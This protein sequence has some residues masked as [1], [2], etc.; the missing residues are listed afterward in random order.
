MVNE[1]QKRYSKKKMAAVADIG[2]FRPVANPV[3]RRMCADNLDLHLQIYF[4]RS[5]G[6][7][8]FSLDHYD[9]IDILDS[10]IRRGGWYANAVFREFAKTSIAEG[11]VLW[12]AMNGRRFNCPIIGADDGAA[13]DI[14]DSIQRE[15]CEND[16]LLADYPEICQ[17]FRHLE[18]RHQRCGSQSYQQWGKCPDC[19]G[20]GLVAVAGGLD[21]LDQCEECEGSG[22]RFSAVLTHINCVGNEIVLPTIR[23]QREV[24][25]E[26]GVPLRPDG[27]TLG[28]G[29]IISAHGILSYKRGSK[30]KQTDGE[31]RRP[32][33]CIVDDFQTDLSAM[34]EVDTRRR[35]KKIFKGIIPSSGQRVKMAIVVNGT[36]IEP[37]DG[38]EQLLDSGK[39][40]AWQGRRIPI[41]KRRATAEAEKLWFGRYAELLGSWDRN[42]PDSSQQQERA[43]RD[44]TEFYAANRQVMDDGAEATWIYAKEP[45]ELSAIQHCYNIWIEHGDEVFLCEGQQQPRKPEPETRRL[46]AEQICS[47]AAGDSLGRGTVPAWCQRLVCYIDVQDACLY[48]GAVAFAEGYTGHLVDY[49]TYPEQPSG[50]FELNRIKAGLNCVWHHHPGVGR[51][52]ALRAAIDLL[53]RVLFGRSWRREDGR[54]QRLDWAAIDSADGGNASIVYEAVRRSQWAATFR[55]ARGWKFGAASETWEEFV[56][57]YKRQG[58]EFFWHCWET[59]I[60]NG[61]RLFKMDSNHWKTFVFKSLATVPGDVGCL[62]LF[63]HPSDHTELASQLLAPKSVL[64]TSDRG[65]TVEEWKTPPGMDD[66]LFDV[67]YGCYALAARLR[68]GI[69]S[70]P[71]AGKHG[72]TTRKFS[73]PAHMKRR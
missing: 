31:S 13:S 57:K 68:I 62:S 7:G 35:L 8:P 6:K 69:P 66:H 41:L 54:D 24:A 27:Y 20:S 63:G 67:L 49:G 34:S 38:M 3:R 40:K 61:I 48:W 64:L 55:A 46:T 5:T 30:A 10:C 58:E 43:R 52:G 45:G 14:I 4:P 9:V 42:S 47:K 22:D 29:A 12:A 1:K 23:L 72:Q 25:D 18:G 65:R 11:A 70:I 21:G 60:D 15:L 17:A 56:A 36:V 53:T 44:A 51:E 50:T 19:Q 37:G 32:D 28:S 2:E 16:L 73:I 39:S 59:P 33:F 26:L 71:S